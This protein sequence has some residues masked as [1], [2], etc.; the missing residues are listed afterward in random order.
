MGK[1]GSVGYLL[2]NRIRDER[3]HRGWSQAEL[4]QALV[5]RGM[6]GHTST[7]AK[8]ELGLRGVRIDELC[9]FADLFGMSVDTLLGRG[10]TNDLAWAIS[11]LTGN[12]QKIAVEIV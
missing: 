1:S 12:A 8:I 4:A 3:E 6:I 9:A 7:I 11:K 2:R 5:T 10:G